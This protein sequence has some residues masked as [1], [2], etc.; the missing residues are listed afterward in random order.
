MRAVLYPLGLFVTWAHFKVA[1]FSAT[2]VVNARMRNPTRN[3]LVQLAA[4]NSKCI[5]HYSFCLYILYDIAYVRIFE[6][7]SMDLHQYIR[8]YDCAGDLAVAT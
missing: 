4:T 6:Y 3:I 5:R 2:V 1:I 8:Q 7:N